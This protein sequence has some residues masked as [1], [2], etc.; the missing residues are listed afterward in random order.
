MYVPLPPDPFPLNTA[1][2]QTYDAGNRFPNKPR[3][4]CVANECDPPK[5]TSSIFGKAS[6]CRTSWMHNSLQSNLFDQARLFPQPI[7]KGLEEL[8][9]T[10]REAKAIRTNAVHVPSLARR[11]AVTRKRNGME[12]EAKA[13]NSTGEQRRPAK[14]RR[15]ALPTCAPAKAATTFGLQ[16]PPSPPP[17]P[18]PRPPEEEPGGGGGGSQGKEGRGSSSHDAMGTTTVHRLRAWTHPPP[19]MTMAYSF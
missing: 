15:R 16:S 12:V 3:I 17:P 7:N 1:K 2:L 6:R 4:E 13:R 14:R 19:P 11:V 9:A 8:Q 5:Q 18:P 10:T